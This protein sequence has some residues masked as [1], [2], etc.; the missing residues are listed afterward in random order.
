[1]LRDIPPHRC[2]AVQDYCIYQ[3]CIKIWFCNVCKR[4]I[5]RSGMEG[6][7]VTVEVKVY[8]M[9]EKKNEYATENL[10]KWV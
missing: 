1:M 7:P 8:V 6:P 5:G 10:E 9:D 3:E 4:I 2:G